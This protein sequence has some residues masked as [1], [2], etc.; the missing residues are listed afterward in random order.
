VTTTT[1]PSGL[2]AL[3]R[4][5]CLR[6][7]GGRCG[8]LADLA[9][10]LAGP[11]QDPDV[12][13]QVLSLWCGAGGIALLA[14]QGPR[15]CVSVATRRGVER[16]DDGWRMTAAERERALGRAAGWLAERV[17]DPG[18]GV[19]QVRAEEVREH[20]EVRALAGALMAFYQT[21]E[22]ELAGH[23]VGDPVE[24]AGRRLD[25]ID[26]RAMARARRTRERLL[27]LYSNRRVLA[28]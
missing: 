11:C 5:A 22:G 25:A 13:W 27:P 23:P 21:V 3:N 28:I 7:F 4:L 16:S 2:V 20:A 18:E 24:A 14:T 26:V 12:L 19:R 9:W 10:G 15:L 6:R 17:A 8:P 1:P